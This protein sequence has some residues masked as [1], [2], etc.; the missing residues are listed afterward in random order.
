MSSSTA[1]GIFDYD[2]DTQ[3]RTRLTDDGE[4]VVNAADLARAFGLK[5]PD[6]AFARLSPEYKVPLATGTPGGVQN[7]IHLREPGVY[8]FLMTVR[9]KESNPRYEWTKGFKQFVCET[10]LPSIRQTGAYAPEQAA[11]APRVL[12]AGPSLEAIEGEIG[13][14][15][16]VVKMLGY[17]GNEAIL[18]ASRR[19]KNDLGFDLVGQFQLSLPSA[20]NQTRRRATDVA[21]VVSE[22]T[23]TKVTAQAINKRL[24]RDGWQVRHESG[25]WWVPTEIGK[26]RGGKLIDVNQTNGVKTVQQLVWWGDEVVD[27]LCQP[28]VIEIG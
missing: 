6:N 15:L 26:A 20:E 28:E 17:E 7:M 3:V 14:S 10:V 27:H 23:A 11:P 4:K 16:R 25:Q 19:I 2:L 8:E 5:R 9:I 22:R 12:P 18:V 13:A 21:V 1:L 24:E